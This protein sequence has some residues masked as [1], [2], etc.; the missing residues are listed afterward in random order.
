[1]AKG[2]EEE[3]EKTEVRESQED[4]KNMLRVSRVYTTHRPVT[5]GAFCPNSARTDFHTARVSH[6]LSRAF[7][8]TVTNCA[9]RLTPP[10]NA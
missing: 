8:P 1:M 2:R 4:E 6:A 9:T 10:R 3:S 5:P 7:K